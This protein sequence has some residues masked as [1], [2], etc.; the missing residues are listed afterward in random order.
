[1]NRSFLFVPGDSERK[2][3]KAGSSPAD[4]LIIDLEDA[5]APDR[6]PAARALVAEA[7]GSLGALGGPEVWARINPVTSADW[8]AD[9]EAAVREGLDGI[10]LPKAEGAPDVVRL[11]D[12]LTELEEDAELPPGGIGILPIVSETAKAMFR[13]ADYAGAS[14]RLRGLTWGAEDLA[15]ALGAT[16]NRDEQG[17]WLPPYELARS[18]CLYA[19]GAAE[20]PAVDTVFADFRNTDGLRAAAQSA[21]RDGFTGMLAIHPAQVPV[22]NDAFTPGT[23][24]IERARRIVALFDEQ[25][26]VGVVGLDGQ[27]LDRPHLIQAKKLLAMA[28]AA[29][30]EQQAEGE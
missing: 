7:V 21:R 10:V 2:L 13:L 24:E 3:E 1:M 16:S 11:A 15:A 23:E 14:P 30:R 27:M 25:P 18:L 5:V 29:R 4:A 8:E 22:I 17:R 20:L 6:R 28:A 9:A 12:R 19:A 26:G